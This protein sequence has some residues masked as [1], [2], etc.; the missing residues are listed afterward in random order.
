MPLPIVR[1]KLIR[2]GA[3]RHAQAAHVRAHHKFVVATVRLHHFK[4]FG[5]GFA[6]HLVKGA[7]L[8]R[9]RVVDTVRFVVRNEHGQVAITTHVR[10]GHS[11]CTASRCIQSEVAMFGKHAVSVIHVNR[12]GPRCGQQ[13]EIKITVTI[14]ISEGRSRRMFGARADARTDRDIFKLPV[15]G[16]AI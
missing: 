3:L 7:Q 6:H 10:H 13:D 16:I 8:R 12:V 9:N 2:L 14:N 11:C 5:T 15:A 1:V 4:P